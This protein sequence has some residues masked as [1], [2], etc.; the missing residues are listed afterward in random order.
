MCIRDSVGTSLP[1]AHNADGSIMTTMSGNYSA[2]DMS[3]GDFDGDGQYEIVMKWR[4][5]ST[6]P[7]YSD[8]IYNAKSLNTGVEYVDVYKMDGTL[9]FRVEMGYNVACSNDHEN[10]L[11]VQDFDGDGKS[12][13]IL[14]T[15]LGTQI[16][17]WDEASQKVVY[18]ETLDTVVG[19]EDGLASTTTCLLYTSFLQ[20]RATQKATSIV[21]GPV[22]KE[23]A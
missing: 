16:G 18:P 14:K 8:P 19:G 23:Y 15:A 12:E 11:Y 1:Y 21:S 9:L 5:G 6:D 7:M 22:K 20:V 13:L 3:L 10:N 17:N 2:Q 4:S